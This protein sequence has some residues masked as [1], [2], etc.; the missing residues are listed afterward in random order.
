MNGI[1][2]VSIAPFSGSALFSMNL[3]PPIERFGVH[4]MILCG[5][6]I[7][8]L[9]LLFFPVSDGFLSKVYK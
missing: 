7:T 2:K 4:F 5:V 3:M 9:L 8:G 1:M 6:K